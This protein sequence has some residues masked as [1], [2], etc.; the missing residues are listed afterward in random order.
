M[1]IDWGEC[2]SFFFFYKQQTAYEMHISYWSSDVCSSY[3]HDDH[4]QRQQ[5]Q[6]A[7]RQGPIEAAFI[8]FQHA[9]E[10]G[11]E[12]ACDAARRLRSEERRGGK[13]CVST[14]S[15]RWLPDHAKRTVSCATNSSI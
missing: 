2:H 7:C 8:G 6:Q 11:L 14:C 5:H 15:S 10:A 9:R 1:H 13:E 3:L 12:P 4:D